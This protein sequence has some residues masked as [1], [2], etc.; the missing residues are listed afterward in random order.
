MNSFELC[1]FCNRDSLVNHTGVV[2]VQNNGEKIVQSDFNIG[3]DTP[4]AQYVADFQAPRTLIASFEANLDI[5][6]FF[7]SMQPALSAYK[8]TAPFAQNCRVHVIEV[9]KVRACARLCASQNKSGF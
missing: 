3:Y 1:V 4:K 6:D 2:L 5:G 7:D 8:P 9:A